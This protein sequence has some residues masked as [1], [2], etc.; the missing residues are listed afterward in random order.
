MREDD[1]QSR[2]VLEGREGTGFPVR[3]VEVR[4]AGVVAA[5]EAGRLAAHGDVLVFTDDDAVPRRDWLARLRD[6]LLTNPRA[7]GVGGRDWIVGNDDPPVH[8]KDVGRIRWYG[9][10]VGAHHRGTGPSASVDVL[11]GVNMAFRR[12]AIAEIGFDARLRGSGSQPHWEFALCLAVKRAG[13]DLI[14]DPAIAVD[15]YEGPRFGVIHRRGQPDLGQLRSTVH[16]ETYA[17]L[18]WLPWWRKPIVLVYGLVVGIREAP[19]LVTALE[20]AS[21]TR[22]W[23]SVLRRLGASTRGR[24]DA[25]GSCAK[26][27]SQEHEN[28][29][30]GPVMY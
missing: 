8:T 11:K 6:C 3:R 29:G 2:G 17:M 1:H 12:K 30:P 10:P 24:L 22:D 5:L 15:H 28:W 16:N 14:Y 9:R 26:A 20:R 27:L 23:R 18:R 19:G 7:G 21:R 25:I 13:W 4:A